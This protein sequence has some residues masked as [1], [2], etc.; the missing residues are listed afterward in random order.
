[1]T[2][3][4]SGGTRSRIGATTAAC[5]SGEPKPAS[6]SANPGTKWCCSGT[7]GA[8]G[9][10]SPAIRVP[11]SAREVRD[12][13]AA[14]AQHLAPRSTT[15]EEEP[16]VD[17]RPDLVQ[18]ELERGH[19]AEVAAA[20]AE[21]PEQVGVLVGRGAQDPPVGGHDLGREEVV[22]GQTGP[23]A[24]PADPAAER[25]PADAG[26]ADEAADRGQ[27]VRLRRGVDVGP[28]VSGVSW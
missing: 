26:V 12:E 8:G 13:V 23:A 3:S 28:G 10:F 4:K 11:M 15:P 24:E 7:N 5:S 1:M 6:S 22:D 18:P 25:E 16:E 21:C 14:E 27:P 19:D 17:D 9:A 20:A 2:R